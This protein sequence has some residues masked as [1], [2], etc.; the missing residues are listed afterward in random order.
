MSV[1]P[2]EQDPRL[3][4][5]VDRVVMEFHPHEV[6]LFGSRAEGRARPDSDYD[7]LVIVDD[8]SP[9][10]AFDPVRAWRTAREAR[11]PADVVVCTRTEFD[12]DRREIDTI[13]RAAYTKGRKVFGD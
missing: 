11:V 6:W 8:G 12:E 1:V 9:P 3:R 5:L 13:A 10:S 4:R 7:V 2:P